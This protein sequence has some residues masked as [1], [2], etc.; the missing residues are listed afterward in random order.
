MSKLLRS[1]DKK[2]VCCS[3]PTSFRSYWKTLVLSLS[4][5]MWCTGVANAQIACD[6]ALIVTCPESATVECTDFEDYF[7]APTWELNDCPGHQGD[8]LSIS[9]EDLMLDGDGCSAVYA[10]VITVTFGNASGECTQLITVQDTQ[11]PVFTS[12][13]DV[14][15]VACETDI[16]PVGPCPAVDGCSA[17]GSNEVFESNTGGDTL[18]C[19]LTTSIGQG[20]DWS[21]WLSGLTSASL[22]SS[23]YYAWVP[24]S[25]TLDFYIDGTA[26][27]TGN[28]VNMVNPAEGWA[29]SVYLENGANWA[30]WSGMGRTFND[31][32]NIAAATHTA[33][34]YYELVGGFSHMVGTG[35][36]A[37]S[38]IY[39]SHQPSTYYKG[40]QCGQGANGRNGNFGMS[41]WFFYY[42]TVNGQYVSSHGDIATD[43]TCTPGNNDQSICDQEFLRVYRAEDACGNVSFASTTIIVDDNVAPVFE[44]CPESFSIECSDE[45]P[46]PVDPATLVATDNCSAVVTIVLVDAG[47]VTMI[48]ACHSS[49]TRVYAADDECQNRTLCSYTIDIYDTTAPVITVPADASYECDMEIV[50][51]EAT[52]TDN[53]QVP[54]I[55]EEVEIVEGDC[56]QSYTIIRNFTATDGCGHY[57]YGTQTITVTDTTAPVLSDFEEHIW[58]ECD[59]LEGVEVPTA[60]DNCDDDVTVSYED[61]LNSGGCLGTIERTFYAADDCGNSVSG[62]QYITITDTTPPTIDEP[63]DMTVECDAVPEAPGEG[64][65][66]VYDNCG[67]PVSVEFHTEMVDG[68]CENSYTI[69]WIW[70]AVDYC[71][72]MSSD[73]TVITVVDTTAPFLSLPEGGTFEC[74]MEIVY[75]EASSEDNC[76]NEVEITYTDAMVPGEC[77]QSYSIVRTFVAVDNCGNM[78]EASTTYYVVDTTAPVFTSVPEGITVECDMDV[79]ASEATAT[80]NCG[81][82]TI[83][84]EDS[85]DNENPCDVIVTR[86]FTA[87]DECG[88]YTMAY[89]TIHI[90]D[91]TAP[92]IV[93][94]VEIDMPCDDI[95]SAIT[96]TATD[97]CDENPTVWIVSDEY[98]SGSCAGRIIR[99]YGAMD[100]CQNYSEFTQFIT[101]IDETAPVVVDQTP[102]FTVECD[103]E[104]AAPTASF[105]D[106]C[107]DELVYTNGVT[108][109]D[110][111]CTVIYTY[112]F[113]ATDECLNS[114][115]T[116]VIVTV[117]DTTNPYFGEVSENMVIE[118]D[119]EVPAPVTP[120]AYDNCDEEVEVTVTQDEFPGDCPNASTIVYVFRAVDNCGNAT[121]V[122][123][124]IQI[125][126]TTA[127]EFTSVPEELT[128]ECDMDVPVTTAT[129]AD[130]CGD[131]TVT[132]EDSYNNEN[133]CDVVVTRTFTAIDECDNYSMA[134]QTIH[135]V[136]TTAPVI[137]AEVE[138]EMPCDDIS[139]T[140]TATATDN[141]DENPTVW[142]VSDEY[143][144]G[145]CAGRIIRIYGAM[146][147]CENYSEFTQ[148]ITLIDET[149]PVVV[150]QTP[151]FT[152]ECD[153]EWVAPMAYF[154]DNCDDELVYTD[155]V[156]STDDGCT[157]IYT[158]SFTATDECLNSTTA[159]VV[160]TVV[161]TTAPIVYAPQGGSFACDEDI[162]YGDATASD[163]CD[164]ELVIDYTDVMTPGECIGN[165]T[166]VRTWTATDNCD[167]I[168]YGSA[169]YYVYDETAPEFTS[170]PEDVTI[171]CDMD[172]PASDATAEDNCGTVTVTQSDMVDD[173]NPCYVVVTRTFTATDDCGN[174]SNAYQTI[175]IVDTTAPVITAEVEIEM[176]CDDISSTITATATDNCDENPTVWIV[177]DE[178]VSGSCAGRII[179]IYGA[180]DNCENYSEFTQFI[181]LIDETAPV[182]VEQT[183]DFTIECDQEWVAPMAYFSDNCD[184][185][186]VYTNDM[187][188]T[189]DGCTVI[190]T[191]SFTA[192]DEC[193]N[194]T[195]ATVVVTVVDTTDPIVTAPQGG[196]F[197][198]DQDIVYGDATATDNCDEELE[199]AYTDVM[200]P[201]ECIGNY[202]IVRTWTAT[203]DCDNMGSASATY[204]VYDE[205]APEFTSVPE[206]VTIE[207][208]MDVPASDATAED[209]CGTVTVTQSDMVDDENPCYV[210]V[211]RTFT[212]SDDCG[213]MSYAYQTITIVDTTAPVI[214]AEV[215]IE[216]PC[217]DISST[218]TATATDNCDENPTVWIE[219]DE[220]VSGSCAGRIIRIYGAYDNCDNVSYFTQFITLIDVTAPVA[221]M[222]PMDATY[223]C[224]EEWVPAMVSFT[225]NCD[226]E[227]VLTDD[228]AVT[229]D[230]CTYVYTYTWTA[231]DECLNTTTVNQVIT[232]TDTTAPVASFDPIDFTVECGSFYDIV[233]PTW[234]DNC[235]EELEFASSVTP[236]TDGC[237]NIYTYEWSAT[238]NCGNTASVGMVVTIVDTTDPMIYV[239]LDNEYSCEE[240][241]D[242]GVASA[243]DACDMEVEIT[244]VDVMIPGDCPNS[245]SIERTWTAT[246]DCGN[247]ASS[248]TTYYVYDNTNPTFD[249]EPSNEAYQCVNW[250]T[251]VPQV[252]TASD[253][254]GAA[255]VEYVIN[256]LDSDECGNG[257][258]EVVYTATDLCFNMSYISYL[259]T[260]E[261]TEA[262]VLSETPGNL[263]IDCND[264]I[265]APMDIT[266][267]DGCDSD[268]MVTVTD[269][270]NGD[271]PEP[272]EAAHCTLTTPNL[273]ANNPCSYP[274][275]WAMG[276]FAMPNAHKW[277]SLVEGT[278]VT[279]VD[280][281]LHA[282]GTLV[283]N[284]NANAGFYFDV[285]FAEGMDY[286]T[287]ST[288]THAT[289]VKAD[290]GGEVA[291]KTSW[292]FYI[293]QASD[294]AQLIGWGDYAGSALDLVHAPANEYFGFQLGD[295]ANNYNGDYGLGGWFSYHGTFLVNGSPIMSG[296]AAGAGDFAFELDCC[297]NY[298]IERCYTAVDC[299]GNETM[300]CQTI[301][302][303]DLDGDFGSGNGNAPTVNNV[304]ADKGS[305]AIVS[306]TPNPSTTNSQ[307]KFTSE[308][309]TQV[310]LEVLDNTG[311]VVAKLFN[312]TV[313]AGVVYTSD[314]KSDRV[315]AGIYFARLS[316]TFESK[317]E[318][319]V[320][321]R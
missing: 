312:G 83:T 88:N 147:N 211:T 37:G 184:E 49:I 16:P 145:S 253:N 113:T 71:E 235:D 104:W 267:A 50:Y 173:E 262:P 191:Y 139:S 54:T 122:S 238:D 311:R 53:C 129:A 44:N 258:W 99:I 307:L 194:S 96:A 221:S 304:E 201:G 275:D 119:M 45:V 21:V 197:S 36:N 158:Y 142:I 294:E 232:V 117:V 278:L 260:T 256:E 48:D 239:P 175:T 289:G 67:N 6:P 90:V 220:Y 17:L 30:Q 237:S 244:F 254:C 22:A 1:L 277:Y 164:E 12:V 144:S 243:E 279:M 227:L 252:V 23:D 153:Q 310:T 171:E 218:I 270:C 303:A 89:Q 123:Y 178:Y 61:V 295:G 316:S 272:G 80:D 55:T 18:N 317:L 29:V 10:R 159:T 46:A 182:V 180:M 273:P 62:I 300:W 7:L 92:V 58:V 192:T 130:N 276:L 261:D 136:D 108:S 290:C 95:S 299:S 163:N 68:P 263:V 132:Y 269:V 151:D 242:Y 190:Y 66:E 292:M 313:E 2:E 84:Q 35:A 204:Y 172:V 217:D 103:Q 187:D 87:T 160:V 124:Q 169:T 156:T 185:E 170:V 77:P 236:S 230:G 79:P 199:M 246:D 38:E 59:Q 102:D 131:V 63:A 111:G 210:V 177:S 91:T 157:V 109:T 205:T 225:D 226:D 320:V 133:P 283:N 115:T 24:G 251:Y 98:V 167:N 25:A 28:V 121:V 9:F 266:A 114:T 149:A 150:E 215:E 74:D 247:S 306:V 20:P 69:L 51:A 75:G 296:Y 155:D 293:L 14:I 281:S 189:D 128:I 241:I 166:I 32:L 302:F 308:V 168:G 42:G 116:S 86:T 202:T 268:V 112:S 97:N 207:C 284:Y 228:V 43:K 65:A 233:V 161:D 309:D 60:S 249:N 212:A 106:N 73:T 301:S 193:L 125:V 152:I 195:T 176:P 224:D 234:S 321:I 219:S 41:G 174:A 213:N 318:R 137:T 3:E 70:D 286:A 259:I 127:P 78:T 126:D 40:F 101:L 179:R 15:T 314:F 186:L 288:Q 229:N 143:V 141:C 188:M 118:C 203:D 297:P 148:F 181:T 280:G 134:Y 214:T 162:V 183:P 57:D 26:I 13:A 100:N 271:C 33:W 135:I 47:T 94:E 39:M 31:P 255:N 274:G 110:D 76:D 93:G 245:Y 223:E 264:A 250:D 216:M 27:L 107:D 265:P 146:D 291:N 138:I 209:N 64:G 85:Y 140:I 56:P 8:A 287:W 105:S 208:D 319:I 257:V 165:Y 315:E 248:V 120:A 282:T 72:N 4:V 240:T 5:L 222:E 154:S 196:Y 19:V 198:C 231:T 82:V 206:N 285:V 11:G 34:M 305:I 298:T 81:E 52:A 200:T